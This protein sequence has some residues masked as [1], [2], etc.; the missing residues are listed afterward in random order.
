MHFCH[1][2]AQYTYYRRGRACRH[3]AARGAPRCPDGRHSDSPGGGRDRDRAGRI[4]CSPS[5]R[6]D[7][8][9]RNIIETHRG[10]CA[11]ELRQIQ[12]SQSPYFSS[13]SAMRSPS[14]PPHAAFRPWMSIWPP[15]MRASFNTLPGRSDLR[16]RPRRH[17][18]QSGGMGRTRT[19]NSRRRCW[20]TSCGTSPTARDTK[21][22][23]KP[24]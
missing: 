22:T 18:A 6:V 4:L 16:A 13:A 15:A 12:H 11:V 20:P 8:D 2:E 14:L 1:Q 19:P 24:A 9:I 10:A 5:T 21:Q 7:G 3:R 17:F 23:K